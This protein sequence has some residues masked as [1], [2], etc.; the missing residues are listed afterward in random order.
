MIEME[1]NDNHDDTVDGAA[2]SESPIENRAFHPMILRV[3]TKLMQDETSDKTRL[4]WESPID[5]D[6]FPIELV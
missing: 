2:K 3:S 5:F 6:D 1:G 4:A